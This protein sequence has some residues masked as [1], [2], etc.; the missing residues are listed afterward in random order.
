VQTD[1]HSLVDAHER[2]PNETNNLET[3]MGG[4]PKAIH[5]LEDHLQLFRALKLH[6]QPTSER[7]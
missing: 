7:S 2:N 1:V 4:M 6:A 5:F 3:D